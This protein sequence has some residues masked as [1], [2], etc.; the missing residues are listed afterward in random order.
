MFG[1]GRWFIQQI[2]NVS[3][4]KIN[5]NKKCIISLIKVLNFFFKLRTNAMFSPN[6]KYIIT[7]TSTNPKE[8]HGRM[9]IFERDSL[10]IVHEIN[11][12]DSV[13]ILL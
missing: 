11:V 4:L 8:E 1:I 12:V 2:S 10:K 9:V 7:G 5:L 6:D 3:F 13:N